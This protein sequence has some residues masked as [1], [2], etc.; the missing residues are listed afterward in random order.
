MRVPDEAYVAHSRGE[1]SD[2]EFQGLQKFASLL[3]EPS[4]EAASPNMENIQQGLLHGASIAAGSAGIL[5]TGA[6]VGKGV[7]SLHNRLTYRRDLNRVLDVHPDIGENYS[8]RDV[9]LAFSSLRSMNPDMAND[10]LIGGNLLSQILRNRDI[11]DPSKAPRFPADVALSL[12]SAKRGYRDPTG[13]VVEQS[14]KSGLG[15]MGKELK[16]RRTMGAK[17]PGGGRP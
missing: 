12:Y 8:P 15:E 16:H 14:L 11:T 5:G 3:G 2:E 1:I 17:P 7:S 10:P 9:N 4:K 6:L 13:D